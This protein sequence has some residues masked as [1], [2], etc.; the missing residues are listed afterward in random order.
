MIKAYHRGSD[1]IFPHS[2]KSYGQIYD[3]DIIELFPP[4]EYKD[5][6]FTHIGNDREQMYLI[7][8]QEDEVYVMQNQISF[9]AISESKPSNVSTLNPDYRKQA[10]MFYC[11]IGIIFFIMYSILQVNPIFPDGDFWYDVCNM[12]LKVFIL[13]GFFSAMSIGVFKFFRDV[14]N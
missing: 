8:Y 3:I 7:S 12:A 9:A 4:F 10:G 2:N 5:I 13:I 1:L 14:E 11:T 6:L